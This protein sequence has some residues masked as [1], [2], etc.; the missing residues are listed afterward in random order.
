MFPN[1]NFE[2]VISLLCRVRLW[3]VSQENHTFARKTGSFVLMVFRKIFSAVQYM[4]A[5]TVRALSRKSNSKISQ[6][7]LKTVTSTCRQITSLGTL[8]SSPETTLRII[9]VTPHNNAG[10]RTGHPSR[11][12]G[13]ITHPPPYAAEDR[14]INKGQMP[15]VA[16]SCTSVLRNEFLDGYS[17]Y[18]F[19]WVA[20]PST[21]IE[22]VMLRLPD[23]NVLHPLPTCCPDTISLS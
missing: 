9:F 3:I 13:T 1:W 6:A 12:F 18:L 11:P 22:S 17:V 2:T 14:K 5:W 10:N 20:L 15:H 21:S 7:F 8:V 4:P 23:A 16:K 19:H